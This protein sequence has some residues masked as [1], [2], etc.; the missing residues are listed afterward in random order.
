[1]YLPENQYSNLWEIIPSNKTFSHVS[2]IDIRDYSLLRSLVKCH[3]DLIINIDELFLK[4][5]KNC[6]TWLLYKINSNLEANHEYIKN[7]KPM[8]TISAVGLLKRILHSSSRRKI[9]F[10]FKDYYNHYDEILIKK[11]FSNSAT[12]RFFDEI[13]VPIQYFNNQMKLAFFE[14][15]EMKNNFSLLNFE[16]DFKRNRSITSTS[17]YIFDYVFQIGA[18]HHIKVIFSE[19]SDKKVQAYYDNDINTNRIKVKSNSYFSIID[20]IQN[21]RLNHAFML[22]FN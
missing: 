3:N 17:T 12:I 10:I 18:N 14:A 7:K 9:Y 19:K 5:L 11:L 21:A 1:M 15:L 16:I 22:A 8:Y 2:T 13:N 20:E 6:T 4:A